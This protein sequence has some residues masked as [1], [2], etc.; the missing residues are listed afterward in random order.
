M[1]STDHWGPRTERGSHRG[2]A[3]LGAVLAGVFG[4]A[5]AFVLSWA[6]VMGFGGF[7][8]GFGLV[9][10]A[11]LL[12][13]A[14]ALGLVLTGF[15]YLRLRHL[16]PVGYVGLE[17]PSFRELLWAV[18]GYVGA[19]ALV[20]GAGMVLTVLQ[21]QPDT[22][23]QAAELGMENPAL[24]LWL[25][26]ISFV[27]IAPGEEFLFRGVI[28]GRLREAFAPALAIPM[29]AALFAFV[30]Y[31]SLTGAAEARLIAI[32]ILFLPSL[33]FGYVYERTA[34]LLVPILIHG[35]YN[36]TLVSMVYVTIKL[37]GEMPTPA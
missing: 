5:A 35:A 20:F 24:L 37:A 8:G 36:A 11:G 6:V 10:T 29:T 30:H 16:T 4:I 2:F 18:G 28:Q 3:L 25:V 31:F 23:N 7:G 17:T 33:V 19:L 14:S 13:V 21:A 22:A 27:V 9:P 34:N 1:D 15:L 12:F 26:P 32:A